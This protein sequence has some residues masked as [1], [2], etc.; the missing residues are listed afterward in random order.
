MPEGPEVS[1][2]TSILKKFINSKLKNIISNKSSPNLNKFRKNLP[3]KILDINNK[4][5]FIYFK[6]DNNLN[7][8][9]TLSLTGH[10]LLHKN[11]YI[12]YEFIT[13]K[14]NFYLQDMRTFSRFYFMNNIE[15]SNKLNKIGPDI[16]HDKISFNEFKNRLLKRKKTKI[17]S[18]LID[19]KIISGIGNYIRCDS[20]YL[21]KLNPFKLVTNLNDT[22]L[23][24][25]YKS[26]KKIIK[27]SYKYLLLNKNYD[28]LVYRKKLTKKGEIIIRERLEKNRNIYWSPSV[29]K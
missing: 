4:G 9:M 2:M 23:Y 5:K 7:L 6:F 12:I 29:Q 8:C 27:K 25:L 22:E 13:T 24:N 20:L 3:S 26:I 15:L 21:A 19:Q 11:K 16:L 17:A 1:Y 14:G 18:A 28:F 10:L